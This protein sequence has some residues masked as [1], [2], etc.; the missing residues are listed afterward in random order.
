MHQNDIFF[1]FKKLVLRSMHQ[2]D[3]KHKKILIFNRKNNLN[4]L[5][6]RIDPRFQTLWIDML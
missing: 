1:I 4:F 3:P 6:T 5:K 2:N